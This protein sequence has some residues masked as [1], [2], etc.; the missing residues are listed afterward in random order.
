MPEGKRE[1]TDLILERWTD[2]VL[3]SFWVHER[4]CLNGEVG[5]RYGALRGVGR[6]RVR[7]QK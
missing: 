2:P 5:P 7:K 6:I 4:R 1:V 3:G